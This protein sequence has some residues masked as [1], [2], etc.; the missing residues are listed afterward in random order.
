M[1]NPSA[2][3]ARPVRAVVFACR[4]CALLGAERAGREKLPLPVGMRVI[5]V[6]CA[7]AV[8]ADLVLRALADGADGVA[9]LGCHL[10]GCRHNNANRNAHARLEVLGDLLESVGIDR[11][12]LLVSWGTAHEAG[13]YAGLMRTFGAQLAELPVPDA[14]LCPS[15]NAVRTA[16]TAVCSLPADPAEDAALRQAVEAV[17]SEVDGVLALRRTEEGILPYVFG[18]DESLDTLTVGDKWPLA[19]TAWRMLRSLPEGASLAVAC[20]SCDA[21]A[22]R[23][24]ISMNQFA[25]SALKLVQVPCSEARQ[26]ACG[27]TRSAWPLAPEALEWSADRF[28]PSQLAPELLPDAPDRFER[29]KDEFRQCIKCYGCRTACPVCVC[30]SCRLEEDGFLPVGV[31]PPEPLAYHLVRAMHIGDKCAECGACQDACPSGL[32]LMAL[33]R[34]VLSSL[35]ERFAFQPGV[36]EGASPLM[37]SHRQEGA[38]AGMPAPEWLTCNAAAAVS[39]GGRE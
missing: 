18:P 8:S 13:Q 22:L 9:V 19:K 37:A 28:P 26:E 7:G 30:P 33:H 34:A 17:R 16:P 11:R 23:S 15:S 27:C 39:K 29:W 5:P 20:R 24:Q 14:G 21:R 36:T 4:W 10:G 38:T 32:P 31:L 12:R 25:A 2:C 6:E 35:R 3:T 1:A